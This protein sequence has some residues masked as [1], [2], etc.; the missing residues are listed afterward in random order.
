MVSIPSVVRTRQTIKKTENDIEK[1][2]YATARLSMNNISKSS[3][4]IS[5]L[6]LQWLQFVVNYFS[7]LL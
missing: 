1:Y 6:D 3:N 7:V 4:T 5:I 2:G